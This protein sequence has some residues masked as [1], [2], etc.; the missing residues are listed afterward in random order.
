MITQFT[1]PSGADSLPNSTSRVRTD[2]QGARMS[3]VGRRD[4]ATRSRWSNGARQIHF[5]SVSSKPTLTVL[6]AAQSPSARG[7]LPYWSQKDTCFGE[8]AKI[9]IG[10]VHIN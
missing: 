1:H 9:A 3:T 8:K 4:G 6:V 7:M 10:Y 2:E 5:S